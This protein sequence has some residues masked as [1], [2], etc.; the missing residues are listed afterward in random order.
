MKIPLHSLNF[1]F[2]KEMNSRTKRNVSINILGIIYETSKT[3]PNNTNIPVPIINPIFCFFV[4]ALKKKMYTSNIPIKGRIGK[5][6]LPWEVLI[7]QINNQRR[8]NK[9]EN[10]NISNPFFFDLMYFQTSKILEYIIGKMTTF[11]TE[12]KEKDLG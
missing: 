9:E 7:M 2:N 6:Y 3:K 1:G 12:I 8:V 10:T 4:K 11:G 5:R